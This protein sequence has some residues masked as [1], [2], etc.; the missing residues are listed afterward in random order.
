M[1][2]LKPVPCSTG[3]QRW[4][5]QAVRGAEPRSAEGGA[6]G[7][8]SEVPQQTSQEPGVFAQ[9]KPTEPILCYV[10]VVVNFFL[11]YS[12]LAGY[13]GSSVRHSVSCIFI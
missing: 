8:E 4:R 3:A 6:A 10:S 11:Q 9:G 12:N 5:K 13:C 2:S 1:A 7:T